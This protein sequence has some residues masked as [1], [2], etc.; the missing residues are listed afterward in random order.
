MGIKVNQ[1]DSTGKLLGCYDSYSTAAEHLTCNES[2]IRKAARDNKLI[3]GKFYF[4]DAELRG[5][6]VQ[7]EGLY[8]IGEPSNLDEQP[9]VIEINPNKPKI[10]FLDIETAP[11]RS[12]TWGLWKQNVSLSQIISNWYIISW[13]GK[14]LNGEEVFSD[15]LTSEEAIN[16]DDSRI[17]KVLWKVLDEADIIIAHNGDAFDIPKINTRFVLHGLM[18][19]SPYRTIDT[20]TIARQRFGFTSNKLDF[21]A[22]FFGYEGKAST[23]FS[24]WEDCMIGD[25]DA[26]HYMDFYCKQDIITLEQVFM[27][28]RPYAK[29]LPNLDM[30]QDA[31]VSACPVCGKQHLKEVPDKF[32]YT[33]AVKY[34]VYRCSDCGGLAR[35]KTG[36]KFENKKQVSAIPR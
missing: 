8:E 18:P 22:K 35:A 29:G 4:E 20:L 2:T 13:A 21:L 7:I 1:F 3:F 28:L 17:M 32:F 12:Y 9:E 26:L 19:P 16:E 24:L 11:L 36:V 15:V 30:Y 10:L 27:K 25:N 14:W 6:D 31:P 34:Q 33:Q 5:L 23:T